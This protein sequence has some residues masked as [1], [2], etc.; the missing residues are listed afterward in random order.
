MRERP[1]SDSIKTATS[2]EKGGSCVRLLLIGLVLT[3]LALPKTAAAHPAYAQR[4]C[5]APHQVRPGFAAIVDLSDL[6]IHLLDGRSFPIAGP[7][8]G[9]ATPRGMAVVRSVLVDPWWYPTD[10]TLAAYQ[11][12]TG[13]RLPK[14][15]APYLRD[16]RN[17][18]GR[19]KVV[20]Y[21]P[22]HRGPQVFRIHGTNRP[23][24]IGRRESRGCIRLHNDHA[25]LVGQFLKQGHKVWFQD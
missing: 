14:A 8:H 7:K 15:V 24:S 13:K 6:C 9:S 10:L 18:M 25:L 2:R 19:L 20:L 22:G 11:Q 12:R 5:T 1:V 21:F 16:Q 17:A 3:V 4:S 23:Q